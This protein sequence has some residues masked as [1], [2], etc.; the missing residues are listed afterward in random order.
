[1]PAKYKA[2]LATAGMQAFPPFGRSRRAPVLAGRFGPRGGRALALSGAWPLE[3]GKGTSSRA[4]FPVRSA[5]C[6]T[7]L[8]GLPRKNPNRKAAAAP[9][10]LTDRA[11]ASARFRARR[12][13]ASC[14]SRA[15]S[16]QPSNG[17][18]SQSGTRTSPCL[19]KRLAPPNFPR[20]AR[21]RDRSAQN[22][23]RS[24]KI[25][26]EN[27]LPLKGFSAF[28]SRTLQPA[29]PSGSA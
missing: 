22:A 7:L 3:G 14:S 2:F 15:R 18:A 24:A 28:R 1:M 8:R 23:I 19:R 21:R 6:A 10:A 29:R 27:G 16:R 20:L 5:F 25:P 11:T 17:R 4:Q 13:N 9:N 12:R 26:K